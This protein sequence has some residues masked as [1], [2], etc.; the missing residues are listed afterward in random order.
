MS[1]WQQLAEQWNAQS[2]WEVVAVILAIAYV[3]LAARQHIACWPCALVSTAIY[4]W[5]FWDNTLPMQAALNVYYL[6]MALYGW[7]HWRKGNQE[8]G[9][10]VSRQS[11]TF[12]GLMIIGCLMVSLSMAYGL[13]WVFISDYLYLDA[14]VTVFSLYATYLMTQKVLENWVYWVVIDA[15]A[16]WLY[17]QTGLYLTSILFIGYLGFAV[18]GLIQWYDSMPERT[19]NAT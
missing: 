4:S 7:W 13:S 6:L 14:L 1:F 9:L 18:Y 2:G 16:A 12:H 15:L 11:K 8:R 10:P 5:L 3:W 19:A 17:W